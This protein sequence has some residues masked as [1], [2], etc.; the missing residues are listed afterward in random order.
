MHHFINANCK[1]TTA[2]P[3]Q[4]IPYSLQNQEGLRTPMFRKYIDTGITT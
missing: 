3:G 4:P 2:L 1:A